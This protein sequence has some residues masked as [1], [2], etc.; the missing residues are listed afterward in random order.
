MP[1]FSIVGIIAMTLLTIAIGRDTLLRLGIGLIEVC[2]LHSTTGYL[3]GY[4][5]CRSLR[6]QEAT[7]RTIAFEVGMQNAGMASAVAAS[8]NKV[9]T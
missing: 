3:L 6:L 9:A 8:L 1:Y 2:F 5:V 7:C 4:L